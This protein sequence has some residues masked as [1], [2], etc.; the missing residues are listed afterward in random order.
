MKN[1]ILSD[2]IVRQIEG[3]GARAFPNEC[4]GMMIGVETD[5]GRIV[6]RIEPADN[7]FEADEQYH[8]FSIPPLQQM[9]S[10]RA[11]SREGK[12]L[13]GFYHS[14]PDHPARPSEYDREHAWETFSYVI[15]EIRSGVPKE[16]T[17][18]M[19]DPMNRTFGQQEILQKR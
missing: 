4:C 7:S 18:W 3:E 15:V 19:L 5:A 10:E 11:A 6:E 17:S 12:I 8:R 1:L 13:I 2:M 16:M 9:K 14:H